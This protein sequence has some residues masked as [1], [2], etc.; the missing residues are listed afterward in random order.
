MS[1]GAE[2]HIVQITGV[3][4]GH[5]LPMDCRVSASQ[6]RSIPSALRARMWRPSGLNAKPFTWSEVV[7]G[8]AAGLPVPASHNCT[9][10]RCC[11]KRCTA[12]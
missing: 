1:V 4:Q 6:T 12:R 8:S 7:N 5:R 2:R 11:R 10:C 9:R 3:F